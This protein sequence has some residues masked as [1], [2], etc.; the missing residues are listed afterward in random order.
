MRDARR[1]TLV[2]RGSGTQPRR[3]D[4][5][6]AAT[7]RVL[8][9]KVLSMLSFVLDHQSEDVDRL[10]LDGAFTAEEFLVLLSSLPRDFLGDVLLVRDGNNSFLST[11][12]RA[13]GRLLYSMTASDIQFYLVAHRLVGNETKAA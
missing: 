13:D 8:F 7:N 4:T 6:A 12:G 9:V 10:V 5:S 11:A 1:V 3:W 2:I